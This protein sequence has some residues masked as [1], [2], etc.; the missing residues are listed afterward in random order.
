MSQLNIRIED[1]DRNEL[2]AISDVTGIKM[3]VLVRD[4][5]RIMLG[6][7]TNENRARARLA[8]LAKDQS[9]CPSR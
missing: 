5:L 6:C 4:A 7:A 9:L 1:N 8:R 3:E 2:R